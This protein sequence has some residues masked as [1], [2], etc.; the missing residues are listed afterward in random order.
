MNSTVEVYIDVKKDDCVINYLEHVE[1]VFTA[2]YS[3]RGDISLDLIS[4]QGR[5]TPPKL[6]IVMSLR[7]LLK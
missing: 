4:A 2:S 3:K 5:T 6:C 7:R 1:L